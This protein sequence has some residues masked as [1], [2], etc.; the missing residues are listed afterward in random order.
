[1]AEWMLNTNVSVTLAVF[2][3]VVINLVLPFVASK[4][5]TPKQISPPNGAAKLGPI[6]QIMHMFVHHNQVMVTSSLIIIIIVTLSVYGSSYV[7]G[8]LNK[9]SSFGY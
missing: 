5:A 7:S 9:P 8:M 1:M 2:I 3:A 6:D 4:I